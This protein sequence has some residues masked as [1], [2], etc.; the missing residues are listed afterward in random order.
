[1]DAS[2]NFEQSVSFG[3]RVR[4]YGITVLLDCCYGVECV[5][6]CIAIS[7][8]FLEKFYPMHRYSHKCLRI[9]K[10]SRSDS[11]KGVVA[12]GGMRRIMPLRPSNSECISSSKSCCISCRWGCIIWMCGFMFST[13]DDCCCQ[14]VVARSTKKSFIIS[15]GSCVRIY[16]ITVLLDCCYG[17]ECVTVCIAIS[18]GFLEKFYPMH[19]YSHKCLRIAKYRDQIPQK[20]VVAEGGMRHIVP[21]R[22]PIL[23]AFHLPIHVASPVAVVASF[24]C[25]V[26]CSQL[27]MI[28]A[29]NASSRVLQRNHSLSPSDHVFVSMASQSC[30]TAVTVLIA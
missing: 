10:L 4:I 24:G 15:F 9:A 1:M 25:V 11:S 26:S 30:T 17:V 8:G 28:V 18:N 27:V 21:L 29:V 5:T 2:Q 23:N 19:R 13:R 7:N 6:V 22:H 14:C 20:G 16:G 12:E 3:S